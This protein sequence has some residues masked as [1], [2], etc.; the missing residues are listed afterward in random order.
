MHKRMQS[1]PHFS[2]YVKKITCPYFS[3]S[4]RTFSI[5]LSIRLSMSKNNEYFRGASLIIITIRH[6]WYNFCTFVHTIK[7][8]SGIVISER[9]YMLRCAS[10]G[11]CVDRLIIFYAGSFASRATQFANKTET[12]ITANSC[13]VKITAV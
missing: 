13:T 8:S 3:Q 10:I 5:R 4:S 1:C 12:L 11:L 9:V 7:G 2:C 6:V